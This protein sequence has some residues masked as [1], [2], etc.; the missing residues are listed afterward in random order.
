MKVCFVASSS[1]RGGSDIALLELLDSLRKQSIDCFV[2]LPSNGQLKIELEKRGVNFKILPYKG[3]MS[4]KDSLAS[5]SKRIIRF[6]W[7]VCIMIILFFEIQKQRPDIVYTNSISVWIGASTAKLVR[8]PHIWHIHEFGFEDNGYV[9][10]FGEKFSLKLIDKLSVVCILVSRAL[11]TKYTHY[12]AP[13]K[14][15]I[16]YQSVTIPRKILGTINFKKHKI[17]CVI[18]G[19]L[20]EGKRQEDAIKA[21]NV[22]VKEDLDIGLWIVGEGDWKY[23]KYL[24][25]IVDDNNIKQYIDFCEWHD[26]PFLFIQKA[27]ISLICSKLEAF[28]RVTI[29]GMLMGKPIIGTKSGGTVESIKEGFNGLLYAPGNYKELAKKIKFLHQN[30]SVMYKMGRNAQQWADKIFTQK[31][32]GEEMLSILNK[33]YENTQSS[34]KKFKN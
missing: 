14:L 7:N 24:E 21:I 28:G 5:F 12:I 27:D 6:F 31:R 17:Q 30:P 15:K 33:V 32:Y 23:K 2:F 3:W 29:E 25:K 13:S 8:K 22:L 19:R 1:G 4:H 16:V 11:K 9:F 34:N 20:A 10:D 18:V 26:D